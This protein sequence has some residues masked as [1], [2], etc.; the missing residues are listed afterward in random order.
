M[1]LAVLL[2][3]LTELA[4]DIA[5][6]QRAANE[7]RHAEIFEHM[8][9]VSSSSKFA[10]RI[11]RGSGSHVVDGDVDESSVAEFHAHGL[12]Q[13]HETA[14]QDQDKRSI[15][16]GPGQRTRARLSTHIHPRAKHNKGDHDEGQDAGN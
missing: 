11:V 8:H 16:V 5:V 9:N 1:Q 14:H 4:H 6:P 12:K 13:H 15:L 2:T 10:I 7:Q 3:H